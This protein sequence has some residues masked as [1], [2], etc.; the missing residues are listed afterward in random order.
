ME[1]ISNLQ[2]PDIQYWPEV[3]WWLAEGLHTDETIKKEI[4]K[5][6]KSGFGAVEF[7]AMDEPGAD[8]ELYGWG[9]EEWVHDSQ[10]ILKE[11]AKK[12]MGVSMTSGTNWSNANLINI[13]PDDKCA[14]KELDFTSEILSPGES[15]T[16]K[17]KPCELKQLEVTQQE[18]IAV[19]AIKRIGKRRKQVLL[20]KDSAIV[21]TQN[22]SDLKLDWSAPGD[23]TY[24]LFTFWLHG[25]GQT[26]TPS[27]DI[28]YT[29]NYIDRYGVEAFIDYWDREVIT[30]EIK[31]LLEDNCRVQMYMDSLELSTYG[32]GGQLWGYHFLEE[33][34]RRRGYD[35]TPYLPFVLKESGGFQVYHRY[36]YSCPDE[37][38]LEKLHNDLYQT[39]TDL[40]M[41]NMLR[42]MQEWLH[43]KGMTLRS[44][45]SYG[46]PFEISQPGKYVDGIET[47]SL[48]FCSQIEAFRNLAGPAHIYRRLY[49][50]ETGATLSNYMLGLE[51]YT[52]II[53]TQFAAGVARTILHGYSSIAG[54]QLSTYWPGH[55]GMWPV[56]SERFGERQPA[57][58]HYKD[59]TRMIA[60]CQ[61]LLR[62]GRPRVDL[63]IIR[64]DYNFNNMISWGLDNHSEQEFYKQK[65]M[66]ANEGFYWKDMNLQNHGYT[67]DYFAPQLLE[68][69][70]IL[71]K[72]GLLD[73]D[74]AGYQAIIIYQE[75]L[76]VSSAKK[77]LLLAQAGLPILFVNGV[78]E[79]LRPE[80]ISKTHRTA[81]CRVASLN[82]NE[83]ELRYIIEQIKLL[84]NVKEINRQGKTIDALYELGVY[85]RVGFAVENKEILTSQREDEAYYYIFVY[86]YM[87]MQSEPKDF[88]LNIQR[89]GRPYKI[90][91]WT[92]DMEG[93]CDCSY[94]ETSTKV[95]L[96]LYPGEAAMIV[97]DISDADKTTN[98]GCSFKKRKIHQMPESIVLPLWNLEV[99]DWD[100]GEKVTVTEDRGLGIVTTE[101]YY[102]T[103]KK[104]ICVGGTL[105]KPWCEIE[106]VGPEVSGVGYYS[107]E[108]MLPP[109]WFPDYHIM[110]SME[111]ACGNTVAVYINQKKAKPVDINHMELDITDLV[112]EGKNTV[113]IEVT[114]TLNNR[115]L[116]RGYYEKIDV[117]TNVKEYGLL[118]EVKLFCQE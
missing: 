53:Y 55:E 5:I 81:A 97:L 29:I 32:M 10:T 63:A 110:L 38:F 39:M 41:E 49:S 90:N 88:T 96:S 25:T 99:E 103:S 74:G 31:N 50:S 87:Y 2:N 84:P 98:Q 23:G 21:L 94:T 77:I 92:A 51:F 93:I 80:G 8:S 76:P 40:Y 27:V 11:T 117:T 42:P 4:E 70:Y 105:L 91:C 1:K 16:G 67:Y 73:Q 15:R 14:A 52:Q 95:P 89:V 83:D 30:D 65:G 114:S 13:K 111:S 112:Q 34:N 100:E 20:D 106:A 59:W 75:V 26:A 54:S 35:L 7:L 18:L 104:R 113:C 6:Y 45:I 64:L 44:E 9:S 107:A 118:G 48:E 3:R 101:V 86:H 78:N 58:I 12:N 19:V 37:I 68:E 109:H 60:R 116:S 24:E 85:P 57:S 108:V 72:N 33:F 82:E 66:R 17:L 79:T 46:L 115:L 36:H 62:Q 71:F 22:V 102:K 43:S 28:S 61:M 56:F 69:E 47:E